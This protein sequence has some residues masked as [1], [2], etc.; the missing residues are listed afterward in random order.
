MHFYSIYF[1]TLNLFEVFFLH[2]ITQSIHFDSH[3]TV[4]AKIAME[5]RLF[6][7]SLSAS[8]AGGRKPIALCSLIVLYL[9]GLATAFLLG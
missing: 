7:R 4:T 5:I 9:L 3:L 6:M 2:P 8:V 1:F